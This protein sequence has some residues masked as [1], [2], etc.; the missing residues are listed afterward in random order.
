MRGEAKAGLEASAYRYIHIPPEQPAPA[1]YHCDYRKKPRHPTTHLPTTHL[2]PDQLLT[3]PATE[4]PTAHRRDYRRKSKAPANVEP[5]ADIVW[6][7]D[8][9]PGR[10]LARPAAGPG[11]AAIAPTLV[12]L[13]P[14]AQ[15]SAAASSSSSSRPECSA[16]SSVNS[17]SPLATRHFSSHVCI[18]IHTYLFV[19][20]A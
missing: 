16:T 2:P 15:T 4:Q 18:Y 14:A 8:F 11:A 13:V 9:Y 17:P 7:A 6:V 12:G 5:S 3:N 20:Y 1:T 19:T 10:P